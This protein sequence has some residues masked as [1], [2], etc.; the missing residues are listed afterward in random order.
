MTVQSAAPMTESIECDLRDIVGLL[1]VRGEDESS[2]VPMDD[3]G[4]DS[5]DGLFSSHR[6]VR[7]PAMQL[8]PQ[9]VLDHTYVHGRRCHRRSGKWPAAYGLAIESY[10]M[11]EPLQHCLGH[12]PGPAGHDAGIGGHDAE[13]TGHDRPEDAPQSLRSRV[14]L[15]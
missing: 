8:E 5:L 9:Y 11:L 7:E 4:C 2:A 1:S 14:L 13:L 15:A 3:T 6:L 10:A 12:D